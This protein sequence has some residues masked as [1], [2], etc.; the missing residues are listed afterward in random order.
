MVMIRDSYIAEE[1]EI[2]ECSGEVI[3]VKIQ[4]KGENPLY[5]S[6]VYRQPSDHSTDQ[7]DQLAA[8]LEQID[9]LTRN[10]P[11]VIIGGDF[12]AR[13]VDWENSN[14]PPGCPDRSVCLRLLE[15]LSQYLL[16]Q[17]NTESTRESAILD[18]FITNKPGLVKACT[19]IPGLS[20]HEVV[21]A[22]CDI[23]VASARKQ[24]RSVFKWGK[25]DR[26]KIKEDLA[27]FRDRFI[28]AYESRSVE[29]NYDCLMDQISSSMKSFIPTKLLKAKQSAPWFNNSIKRMCKKKQR[30]F[31]AARKTGKPSAWTRYKVVLAHC[32]IRAASARKQPRSVFKWGKADRSKIKE[33]LAAF[34]DRFI[35]AYESRSVEENYNCLMDQ[36][37]SSMKSFIPTKLLKAKQSAP[38]FNNS[39]KRMCK[40]KQRLFSAARKTGKPSAWTRYKAFKR[41]T[42]KA[43]HKARW[44]YLNDVLSLSLGEGNSKPFWQYVRAQRQDDIGIS[45]LMENGN[46]VSDAL[47]K[48]EILSR[49]FSSVFTT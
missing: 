18:L 27:A 9:N 6:S 42:L 14:A 28:P 22:H 31:S 34:R 7:L 37:S 10:N 35:P 43:I 17:L 4:L 45:A 33:D 21:L 19:V 8:S 48:A 23:R 30:L 3:W 24:P 15:I 46:L 36:I 38:W 41:D 11:T 5:V 12:N 2:S 49:Q 39:I 26:S 20:D 44:S 40:K 1:V 47:G 25:A 29:E 16:S 13:G 32:D